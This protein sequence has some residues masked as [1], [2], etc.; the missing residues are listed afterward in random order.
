MSTRRSSRI[1]SQ[2]TKSTGPYDRN[3]EQVLID[4]KVYPHDYEYP[5]GSWPVEPNNFEEIRER[6]AQPRPSLLPSQFSDEHFRQFKRREAQVRKERQVYEVVLPAIE[7]KIKD[8]RCR[9]GGI[10]FGNLDD[11]TDHQLHSGN[12]DIYYGAR[13]ELLNR[14]VRDAIGGYIIPS[15]QHD[16]PAAPNF[17]VAAKGP[18]GSQAVAARQAC[19]DGAL[20]ARGIHSLQTYKQSVPTLDNTAHTLTSI[21]HSGQLK[22]YTSHIAP[23]RTAGSQT[24][25]HMH[26]VRS[27]AMTD[28]PDA[29]RAGATAYRNGRDWAEQQRDAAILRANHAETEVPTDDEGS[30]PA[31]S[32]V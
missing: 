15:T 22:I 16:L 13:P 23:L 28:S 29:F 6:L 11:L 1:E 27:F 14:S 17:F 32:S 8:G 26:Q 19:Y 12:P 10:P 30:S 21:Y 31:L 2:R 18:D 25:T 7:G 3:F 5:D 20:G 9:S 24:E 4:S